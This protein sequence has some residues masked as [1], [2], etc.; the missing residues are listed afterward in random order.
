MPYFYEN[1]YMPPILLSVLLLSRMFLTTFNV[2]AYGA[3]GND[4]T[5]DTQAIQACLNAAQAAHGNVYFPAGTYYINQTNGAGKILQINIGAS[6]GASIFGPAPGTGTATLLT[7]KDTPCVQLY[8]QATLVASGFTL[9]N[10]NFR[11]IHHSTVVGQTNALYMTGTGGNLIDTST[12]Q[13]LSFDGYSNAVVEQGINYQTLK[14]DT[15]TAVNGHSEAQPN[16]Q[17]AV[18]LWFADNSNGQCRNVHVINCTATGYTGALPITVSR[19]MDGFVYGYAY[20]EYLTNNTVSMFSQEGLQI[21]APSFNPAATD[22]VVVQGNWI[23]CSITSGWVDSNGAAHKYN[24]GI[25]VDAGHAAINGNTVKNYTTGIMTRPIDYSGYNPTNTTVT[26]NILIQAQDTSLYA[27]SSAVGITAAAASA[28][29]F[30]NFSAT[31]NW[32]YGVDTNPVS[33]SNVTLPVILNF[34]TKP[35]LQ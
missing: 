16:N 12:L 5:D 19:P 7:T 33:T 34:W 15:W 28:N 17:P 13:N 3:T 22:T 18:F 14:N 8:I 25:R 2:T 6:T 21:N 1:S 24:Y 23:D 30:T 31:G 29:P 9:A 20:G 10:L 11:N 26:G 27:V 4:T 32:I 35:I